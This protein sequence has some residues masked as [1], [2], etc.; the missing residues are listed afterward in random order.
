MSET[1]NF[2]G[3]V[4]KLRKFVQSDIFLFVQF[5]LRQLR[6]Y[7]FSDTT[8]CKATMSDVEVAPAYSM[9]LVALASFPRSGN[10]WSRSLIQIATK[11]S[12]GS[13]HWKSERKNALKECKWYFEER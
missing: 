5:D 8:T 3:R 1:E 10:T 12:T 7:I 6:F 4:K 9:P 2:L 13:V 11:Y